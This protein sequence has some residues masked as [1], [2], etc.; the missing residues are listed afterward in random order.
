[1][2]SAWEFLTCFPVLRWT[3]DFFLQ[4]FELV[5]DVHLMGAVANV[6]V[7][8]LRDV[9]DVVLVVLLVQEGQSMRLR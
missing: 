3:I 8:E 2:I 1:M 6:R 9:A 5:V 7:T 4:W